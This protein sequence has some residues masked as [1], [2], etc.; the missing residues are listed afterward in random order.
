MGVIFFIDHT[1]GML[2]F[3]AIHMTS[4]YLIISTTEMMYLLVTIYILAS[5]NRKGNKCIGIF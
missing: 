3:M 2:K 4:Y 1:V 5:A